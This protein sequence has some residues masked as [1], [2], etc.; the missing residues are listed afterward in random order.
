MNAPKPIRFGFILLSH[1]TLTAF[2]GMIDVLRLASDDGDHSRP[3]RCTWQVIDEHLD[4]VRSSTGIQVMP[5]ETLGDPGR[6]DY[7]VV[8]GGL[9]HTRP[10]VSA[11]VLA[12]IRAAAKSHVTLVGLCTGAFA[13]MQAGVLKGHRV[14]VSWFHYWDFV[15]Q[16]PD[17]DPKLIIA[18]RLY[19]IDRRR[20]TCSG[21][22]ASIDVAADILRRH[23]DASIVQ[24]ALRILLVDA[25]A[26]SDTAQPSPPGERPA[27]HPIVRR[28]M[29]LMEQHIGQQLS[30][31]ELAARLN[32]SVRQLERLFREHAGTT[33][34]AYA[35]SLRL[36]TA[37]WQLTHSRRSIAD[38]AMSCG[39]S[40][41]SHLGREFRAT[42][43][44]PPSNWRARA[45]LPEALLDQAPETP[46]VQDAGADTA[47]PTDTV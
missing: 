14:C 21:G 46:H 23:V 13:M 35:R 32:I 24:K 3:V 7:L 12:F 18:D 36:R 9:L 10:P 30:L 4:P 34:H 45:Q 5:S 29:L 38:I 31:G 33:P 44:M 40:D 25:A 41:A 8:V 16:F 27:L 19:T 37:A 22:R 47:P 17:T 11:A 1:F 26:R 42:F 28:A 6:F 20:I 2:S 15:E 39:F 43:G